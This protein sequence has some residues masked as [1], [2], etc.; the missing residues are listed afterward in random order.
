MDFFEGALAERF[1]LDGFI[2][3]ESGDKICLCCLVWAALQRLPGS[4]KITKLS[5]HSSILEFKNRLFFHSQ[6]GC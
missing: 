2:L 4:F 6:N 5:L 3:Q 1:M